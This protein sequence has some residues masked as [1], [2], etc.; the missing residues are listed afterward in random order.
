M[1][2]VQF[3][4]AQWSPL[5]LLKNGVRLIIDDDDMTGLLGKNGWSYGTGWRFRDNGE[6]GTA[7]GQIEIRDS[8]RYSGGRIAFDGKL[9]LGFVDGVSVG[10]IEAAG[11]LTLVNNASAGAQFSVKAN[12][13]AAIRA[14]RVTTKGSAAVYHIS[15]ENAVAVDAATLFLDSPNVTI[16][17][18]PAVREGAEIDCMEGIGYTR[19]A[20]KKTLTTY[21]IDQ[22][23][24]L[25]GNGGKLDGKEEMDGHLIL[26]RIRSKLRALPFAWKDYA[27]GRLGR[28][29]RKVEKVVTDASGDLKCD[30]IRDALRRLA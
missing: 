4:Y 27:L 17:G 13:V 21:A 25:V 2:P 26:A 28:R 3:L 9:T 1:E 23:L 14:E 5:N 18:D 11:S 19:S 30:G 22:T 7:D 16:K 29:S 20:D 10:Q 24:T 12:G 6:H 8:T 15:A